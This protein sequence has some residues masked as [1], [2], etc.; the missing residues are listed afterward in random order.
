MKTSG[1]TVYDASYNVVHLSFRK[2]VTEVRDV[3]EK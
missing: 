2:M 3:R 1:D